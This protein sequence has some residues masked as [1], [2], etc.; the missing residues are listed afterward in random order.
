MKMIRFDVLLTFSKDCTE[1]PE[2][3]A[4]GL[5]TYI[6]RWGLK[7]VTVTPMTPVRQ[8]RVKLNDLGGLSKLSLSHV[9]GYLAFCGVIQKY[10]LHEARRKAKVF[11][12][13]V[14]PI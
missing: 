11:N 6:K 2:Q 12:G 7:G 14:E 5:K 4:E 3:L 13:T 9:D 1:T 10:G 8:Y